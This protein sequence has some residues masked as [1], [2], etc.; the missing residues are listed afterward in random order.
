MKFQ[1]A[2]LVA[3]VLAFAAVVAAEELQKD[4][5]VARIASRIREAIEQAEKPEDICNMALVNLLDDAKMVEIAEKNSRK[6]LFAYWLVE[7]RDE[8][9][10]KYIKT[11]EPI[12][13]TMVKRFLNKLSAAD[14]KFR[15]WNMKKILEGHERFEE[16]M[17]YY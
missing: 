9:C 2:F 10:K 17:K 8:L 3:A 11:K 4:E 7:Q 6:T 16:R 14:E 15:V 1:L 13:P 5:I 12:E